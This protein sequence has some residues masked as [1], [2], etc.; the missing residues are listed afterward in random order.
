MDWLHALSAKLSSLPGI[1]AIHFADRARDKKH[2]R[3]A[4]PIYRLALFLSP[5][6]ASAWVQLGHALKE[7]GKL[8]QAEVAYVT[9]TRADV[10]SADAFLQLGQ[11]L[12]LQGNNK[13]AHQLY[14]R[15]LALS[16]MS[17]FDE[18]LGLQTDI[19]VALG[20]L[21]RDDGAWLAAVKHYRAATLLSA[22]KKATVW[23]QL[24]HAL[25]ETSDLVGA[26]LAYRN[27]ITL[28]AQSADAHLHLGHS[29]K[30][31]ARKYEAM[32]AYLAAI[33]IQDN[34]DDAR[35]ALLAVV[36]YS[37]SEFD[38]IVSQGVVAKQVCPLTNRIPDDRV[39]WGSGLNN[40]RTV[41]DIVWLSN[42][43]WHF[44]TQ[45]PQH[46]ATALAEIGVRV[47]YVSMTFEEAT[48]D[49][50]FRT[51]GCPHQRIR[52]IRVGF[53]GG[54]SACIS[55]GMCRVQSLSISDAVQLAMQAYEM[56]RPVV[57]VEDPNWND[58]ATSLSSSLVV[59][60][61]VD[62]LAGFKDTLPIRLEAE[63]S[64]LQK[65]DIVVVT[66]AELAADLSVRNP[67]IVRNGVDIDH[68][69]LSDEPRGKEPSRILGYYGA[70]REWFAMDWIVHCAKRHPDWTFWLIG[71]MEQ[72]FPDAERLPNVKFTASAPMKS[73]P[74]FLNSLM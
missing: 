65:A 47:L 11:L 67:S 7:A 6:N 41:L 45:R 58:V 59:Y 56:D 23:I 36:G 53:V 19:Q 43:E 62:R 20:N 42:V 8:Q 40:R 24:G 30:L 51:I 49:T 38:K 1:V 72:R 5:R 34:F 39:P 54:H 13:L 52:E 2:W 50:Y 25:K 21:A 22:E 46:L 26:E 17:H 61:C 31:Q 33:K 10:S 12:S 27:A 37:P 55:H 66:S 57:V 48:S 44:R 18:R 4:A 28:D 70:L 64:L 71:R 73:F 68:F 3:I 32:E 69:S 60:D 15:A 63:A 29:L 16:E 74:S 35:H 14:E 9:A